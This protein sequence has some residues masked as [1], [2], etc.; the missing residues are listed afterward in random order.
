MSSAELQGV[1]ARG[2]G[3]PRS[4]GRRAVI[5]WVG[6][7]LLAAALCPAGAET[8]IRAELDRGPDIT[9]PCRDLAG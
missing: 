7:G 6:V 2:L 4:S 5:A 1:A 9:S 8:S 3:M